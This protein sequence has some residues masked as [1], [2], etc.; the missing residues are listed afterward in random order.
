MAHVPSK[1]LIHPTSSTRQTM[2]RFH[3]LDALRAFAML[4]GVVLHASMFLVWE[5]WLVVAKEVSPDLPY[6]DIVFAIHGFRMPVFF[7]LSG[8]FTAMLWQR[9]GKKALINHRFR[10]VGLPLL[11]GA[12]TIIPIHISWFVLLSGEEF[13]FGT[14]VWIFFLGWI[15]GLQHLWFLWM[16]LLLVGLFLGLATL[17]VSF[18]NRWVWWL[19]I[20]VVLIPQ[21][22]MVEPNWGPDTASHLIVNPVVLAYYLCFFLFGAFMYQ[23]EM[24]IERRW[25][26]A[27]LP[28]LPVFYVGLHFE[29][30]SDASWAHFVSSCLQVVFAWAMCFGMMGLLK[31]VAS[32][33]RPWVR[34]M[35]DASYWIYLW[36]LALIFP[37]QRIAAD[38]DLNV[39]F[40]VL[41]IMVSVTAILLISYHFA[42]RYTWIG[43]MLNGPRTRD[44]LGV[45]AS[46]PDVQGRSSDH[47]SR[48]V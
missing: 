21:L 19:L 42:V 15:T 1:N 30:I 8:F 14:G 10:R 45:D 22:M 38:L 11:I 35:S 2:Q 43:T 40:E 18:M 47:A 26:F 3:E 4:L 28:V 29:F 24:S 27:L 6:D 33:E 41:A 9:R 5:E 16:L 48:T 7:L 20:P 32:V 36:H 25:A 37:A 34:Y 13:V 31:I 44:D 39:H 17:G 23:T 12:F 46:L